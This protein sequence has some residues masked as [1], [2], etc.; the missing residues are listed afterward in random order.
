MSFERILLKFDHLQDVLGYV[1]D[2]FLA[3]SADGKFV[4]MAGLNKAITNIKGSRPSEEEV[5]EIFNFADLHEDVRINLKE[6]VVALTL[7]VVL[8]SINFGEEKVKLAPSPRRQ[9]MSSFFGHP[10]EVYNMLSLIVSA[11]LLF[12]KDGSGRI[13]RDTVTKLLDERGHKDSSSSNAMLSQERWKELDWDENGQIDLA[14]FVHA[15][16]MWVDMDNIL[17][18]G[19][20]S[21]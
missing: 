6:F 5:K 16:T 7:G 10:K 17:S 4:D 3:C 19:E 15:F 11:Y 1:K 12:D 18:V 13:Q 8:D 20:S 21:P 14:E 9:S 2:N